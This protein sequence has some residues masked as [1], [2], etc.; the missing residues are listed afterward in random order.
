MDLAV[1]AVYHTDVFVSSFSLLGLLALGKRK[2]QSRQGLSERSV[3]RKPT[4][5]FCGRAVVHLCMC[6]YNLA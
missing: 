1:C 6:Y 5:L 3:S 2:D 4:G